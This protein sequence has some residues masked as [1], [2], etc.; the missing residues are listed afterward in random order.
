MSVKWT[1]NSVS[2]DI[3][4]ESIDTGIR[5]TFHTVKLIDGDPVLQ[6]GRDEIP[7]MSIRTSSITQDTYNKFKTW[8]GLSGQLTLVD[9]HGDSL[10]VVIESLDINRKFAVNTQWYYEITLLFKVLNGLY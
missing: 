3:N 5:K 2:F 6:Q 4:P 8:A 9:D 10:T 7:S 1:L